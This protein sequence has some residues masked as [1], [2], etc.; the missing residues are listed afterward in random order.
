MEAFIPP[1]Y[2]KEAKM[3]AAAG[4]DGHPPQQEL[5]NPNLLSITHAPSHGQKERASDI[6]FPKNYE[7]EINGSQNGKM[8]LSSRWM[9]KVLQPEGK[10]QCPHHYSRHR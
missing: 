9:S 3:M 7:P 5:N 1:F 6:L 4:G 8:G 2:S 10:P